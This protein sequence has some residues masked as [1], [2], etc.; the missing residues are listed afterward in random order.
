MNKKAILEILV[1]NIQNKKIIKYVFSDTK[2]YSHSKIILKPVLIKDEMQIQIE[3]FRENKAF[4]SNFHPNDE[5]LFS[6]INEYI[7]NFKQILVQ[8]PSYDLVFNKKK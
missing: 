2:T 6:L 8:I 1:E 5:K 4:H 7:D 3:S